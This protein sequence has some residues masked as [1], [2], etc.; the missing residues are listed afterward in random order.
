MT[1]D[2]AMRRI[3]QLHHDWSLE[4]G[5]TVPYVEADEGADP[6]DLSLWQAD[7]SA[8]AALQDDLNDAIMEILNQIEE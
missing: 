2:E 5:D 1:R 3:A 6:T 7:R 4:H 8:P